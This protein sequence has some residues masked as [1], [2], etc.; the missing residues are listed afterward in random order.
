MGQEIV[1]QRFKR[2]FSPFFVRVSKKEYLEELLDGKIYMNSSGF[3]RSLDDNYRGD[4]SDGKTQVSSKN[5]LIV[6]E[7]PITGERIL[8][9]ENH[10]LQPDS[11]LF[12]FDGDDRVPIFCMTYLDSH[13]FDYV[14]NDSF[15]VKKEIVDEISRFGEY[16][17]SFSVNEVMDRIKQFNNNNK[18]YNLMTGKVEYYNPDEIISLKDINTIDIKYGQYKPFFRKTEGYKNQHEWRAVLIGDEPALA[19]GQTHR[20]IYIDRFDNKT[21]HPIEILRNAR[22]KV[23][24]V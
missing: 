10:G 15:V 21:I 23:E 7:D 22:F 12:G 4:K 1:E 3:F 2:F 20:Y 11:L 24:A 13:A 18:D 14:G 9:D 6:I 8:F 19:E 17:V 16:F 5:L